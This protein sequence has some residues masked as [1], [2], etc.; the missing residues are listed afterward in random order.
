MNYSIYLEY[1]EFDKN[2]TQNNQGAGI[3]QCFCQNDYNSQND[4]N[5]TCKTY[6][7]DKLTATV[8]SWILSLVVSGFNMLIRTINYYLIDYIGYDTESRRVSTIMTSIFF[9]SLINTGVIVLFTNAKLTF[10]PI[11]KLFPINN[12]YT[13]FGY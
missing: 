4:P 13:D 6:N 3:Y 12:Q 5:N 10:V 7:E 8:F 1:A 9:A 11:L 2:Y